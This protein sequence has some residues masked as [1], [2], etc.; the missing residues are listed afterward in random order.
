MKTIRIAEDTHIHLMS[1][2]KLNQEKNLDQVIIK[3]IQGE[4]R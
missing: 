4:K 1:L 2:K 3:L